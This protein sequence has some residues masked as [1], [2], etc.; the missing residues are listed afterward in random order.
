MSG[1]RVSLRPDPDRSLSPP[2]AVSGVRATV[3]GRGGLA[4]ETRWARV[5]SKSTD[6]DQPLRLRLS[7]TCRKGLQSSSFVDGP[8][9]RTSVTSGEGTGLNPRLDPSY[10]NHKDG[11]CSET[12][13]SERFKGKDESTSKYQR[14]FCPIV[15]SINWSPGRPGGTRIFRSDLPKEGVEKDG[16]NIPVSTTVGSRDSTRPEI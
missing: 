3:P 10:R 2:L 15:N 5:N 7:G 14:V 13:F 6:T 16:G 1:T 9:D 11:R 4:H 8:R 12:S